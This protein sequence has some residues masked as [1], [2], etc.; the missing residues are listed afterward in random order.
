MATK[1]YTI[2]E[3]AGWAS[4]AL[5]TLLAMAAIAV[6]L[7]K[8]RQRTSQARAARALLGGPQTSPHGSCASATDLNPV[9]IQPALAFSL[10]VPRAVRVMYPM[11]TVACFWLYIWADV[12]VAAEVN[13]ALEV[14]GAPEGKWQW[15]GTMASLTLLPAAKDAWDGGAKA[16]AILLGLLNGIWPFCQTLVLLTLG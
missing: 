4:A 8:G 12:S 15:S 5:L 11:F 2:L 7:I 9:Q 6:L 16:T 14:D 10:K 3:Y 1:W 13:A